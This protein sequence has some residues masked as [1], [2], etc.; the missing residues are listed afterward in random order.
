[1]REWQVSLVFAWCILLSAMPTGGITE[2]GLN[3][4]EARGTLAAWDEACEAV[5]DKLA[6]Q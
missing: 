1:M 3:L 5:K 6:R 4:L 2:K